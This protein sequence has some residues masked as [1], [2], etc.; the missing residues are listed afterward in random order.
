MA[1]YRMLCCNNGIHTSIKMLP[2]KTVI[3]VE[4]T[5]TV[6][7]KAAI[8]PEKRGP[9]FAEE[10]SGGCRLSDRSRWDDKGF[11]SNGKM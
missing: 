11:P 4:G 9:I 7:Y 2:G 3:D 1:L 8:L 10:L 5:D 6:D